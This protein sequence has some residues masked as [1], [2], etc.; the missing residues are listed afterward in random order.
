[1]NL[2]RMEAWY[3][4]IAVASE[5]FSKSLGGIGLGPS[6]IPSPN[7]TEMNAYLE[8][9]QKMWVRAIA[10]N[11]DF[12]LQEYVPGTKYV[13]SSKYTSQTTIE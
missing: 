4:A 2:G 9:G 6:I 1:M 11:S 13:P 12:V 10:H 3:L 8:K 5:T 7:N